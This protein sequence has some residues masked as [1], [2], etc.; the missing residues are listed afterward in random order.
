M[1]LPD[2]RRGTVARAT[3]TLCLL[4]LLGSPSA[5]KPPDTQS[6]DEAYLEAARAVLCDCG[7][8][9]QSVDSCSCGRADEL[10][11]EMREM[12]ES[13][14]SGQEIIAHYVAIHGEQILIAPKARGFNLVAWLLPLALLVLSAIVILLVIRRWHQPVAVATEP[15]NID[16]PNMERLRQLLKDTE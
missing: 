11:A 6:P 12:A 4:F 7:C 15:V 9:P 14:M 10:S 1:Q 2:D 16:D 13:N 3:T 8:H 5:A